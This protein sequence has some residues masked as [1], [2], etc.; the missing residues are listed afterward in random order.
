[1]MGEGAE[2][3]VCAREPL[4]G[5][6]RPPRARASLRA[7]ALT[8][9]SRSTWLPTTV[10]AGCVWLCV[11]PP[12]LSFRLHAPN[13]RHVLRE[14]IRYTRLARRTELRAPSSRS[15]HAVVDS[16]ENADKMPKEYTPEMRKYMGKRIS[17]KLN[18]NR[19]VSGKLVGFD[20]FMNLTLE[21][22]VHEASAT[23]K[24]DIGLIII[25]GNS[26]VQVESL[27]RVAA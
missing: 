9:S 27:D 8:P 16:S 1:M 26:I 4:S 21:E 15:R 2:A 10:S 17:I 22:G 19:V 24:H 5:P 25:R 6:C 12:H 14:Q 11:T 7:H 13:L 23:E 18:G 3:R 20:A